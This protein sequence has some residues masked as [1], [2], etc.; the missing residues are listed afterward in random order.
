MQLLRD[1][2]TTAVLFPS[3]TL[4]Q[5]LTH[6]PGWTHVL[7]DNGMQLFV[8]GDASWAAGARC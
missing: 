3:G 2:G 1:S 5:Q 7:S 4:T 8:T 6:A